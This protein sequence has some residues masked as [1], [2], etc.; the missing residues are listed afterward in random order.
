MGN[1]SLTVCTK[2]LYCCITILVTFVVLPIP[3]ISGACRTLGE[4]KFDPSRVAAFLMLNLS[5]G[6]NI[7]EKNEEVFVQG[8][9]QTRLLFLLP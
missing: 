8:C 7:P 9:L 3:E 4:D 5:L 6:V 2:Q 1:F